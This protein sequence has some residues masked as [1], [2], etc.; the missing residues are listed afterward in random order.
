MDAIFFDKKYYL[1]SRGAE[2]GK[3]YGL[4]EQALAEAAETA[5]A[6]IATL[7]VRQHE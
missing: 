4:L 3:V 7:V 5:K 6:G 1:G 2:C